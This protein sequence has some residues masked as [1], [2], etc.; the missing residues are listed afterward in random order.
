MAFSAESESLKTI[1]M[2]RSRLG[3]LI[4][5]STLNL[6]LD[7]LRSARMV[8]AGCCPRWVSM[9]L[10]NLVLLSTKSLG[11]M[12]SRLTRLREV[13]SFSVSRVSTSVWELTMASNP[14]GLSLS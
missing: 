4:T 8:G 10:M 12:G 5:S 3:N 9:P 13:F 2:Q 7:F 14:F 11:V 6:G 1:L